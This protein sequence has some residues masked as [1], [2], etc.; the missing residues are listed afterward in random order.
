MVGNSRS[1]S[2]VAKQAKMRYRHQ[3][4]DECPWPRPPAHQREVEQAQLQER[5][6]VGGDL[7]G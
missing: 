4:G 7:L 6:P 2:I 5:A 3:P 1:A